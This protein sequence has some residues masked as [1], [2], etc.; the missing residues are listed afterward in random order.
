MT[1]TRTPEYLYTLTGGILCLDF[2]NTVDDRP[3]DQP[4][5]LLNNYSGLVLWSRQ[6]GIITPQASQHLVREARRHAEEATMI[7]EQA[8]TLREAIYRMFSAIAGGRMPEATDLGTLNT[9]L[10]PALAR[11]QIIPTTAGFEWG[12]VVDADALDQVLWPV[13]RSAAD[14]LTSDDLTAVRECAG[15]DCGWLFMDRSRTHRRRWCDMKICG[16]R[17]KA[18]RHYQRKKSTC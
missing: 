1:Q 16:N 4:I 8:M 5:E 17:E 9:A 3:T 12:W 2:A 11:S 10:T 14:L 6:A 7:L 15:Y 13:A 18:R